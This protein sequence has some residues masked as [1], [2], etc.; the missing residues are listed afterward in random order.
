[1]HKLNATQLSRLLS[2]PDPRKET[3]FG[4]IG[5]M[6]VLIDLFTREE[7]LHPFL[8]FL[9]TYY[10]VTKAAAEKYINRKH[11]F[12]S[13][14]DY[15]ILD[16]YFA[17]LY[18]TPMLRFLLGEKIHTPWET[19]FHYCQKKSGIPFLQML[20][21]INAHINGD[22]YSA[23]VDLDYRHEKDFFMVNDILQEVI[24]E[25]T[26]YLVFKEHDLLSTPGLVMKDFFLS[27]FHVVIEK[28]R[29]EAW[30][31]AQ[32]KGNKKRMD[33]LVFGRT[34]SLGKSLQHDFE[35]GVAV[36]FLIDTLLKKQST[37]LLSDK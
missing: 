18:F 5:R 15:E 22:L 3:I 26:A 36:P 23:I 6:E 13:L 31:N 19:Y 29:S 30:I 11:F 14:R 21:G 12:W 10:F 8:P 2:I 24:P 37:A 1:M 34:E 7:R 9:K 4:V 35:K 27:E 33:S 16:V 25:V 17:T 20:L 28:W 32:Q